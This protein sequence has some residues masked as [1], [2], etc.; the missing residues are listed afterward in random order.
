MSQ[1]S[2]IVCDRMSQRAPRVPANEARHRILAAARELLLDRPFAALTVGDVMARAGLTRTVFYRHFEGLPQLAPELLPDAEDPLVDQVLRGSPED[3]IDT[4]ITGLVGL[5][6]DNG[7]WLRAIDAAASDPDVAAALDRA[8]D[9]STPAI[10]DARRRRSARAAQPTRVRSPT[11]GD[12]PGIPTRQIRQRQRHAGKPSG[13]NRRARRPLAAASRAVNLEPG[14]T[15]GPAPLSRGNRV[16][17]RTAPQPQREERSQHA[18]A[19]TAALVAGPDR[20]DGALDASA[21]G[22]EGQRGAFRTTPAVG[23]T[24][25]AGADP[26]HA[27]AR[28]SAQLRVD[29]VAPSG[30]RSCGSFDRHQRSSPRR[31]SGVHRTASEPGPRSSSTAAPP[32]GSVGPRTRSP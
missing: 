28:A 3:L 22:R 11:D 8:L 21:L 1:D 4:M 25:S 30:A 17:R 29:L 20:T 32:V 2:C 6:A 31:S 9:G 26:H 19:N 24:F 14:Q 10:G 27:T 15:L 23:S 7:R 16:R 12:P 5:Y 13:R 18:R